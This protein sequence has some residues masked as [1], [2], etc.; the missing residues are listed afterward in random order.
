MTAELVITLY[1]DLRS[2]STT[3]AMTMMRAMKLMPTLEPNTAPA[4]DLQSPAGSHLH[5]VM[6]T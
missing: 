3:L 1:D 5:T 4:A 6:L 2:R